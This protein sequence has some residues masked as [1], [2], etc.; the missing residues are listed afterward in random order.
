MPSPPSSKA[1]RS[2]FQAT[3]SH[4]AAPIVVLVAAMFTS[5][6]LDTWILWSA[7]GAVAGYSLSGST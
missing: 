2:G 5:V 4:P 3:I 1:T 7:A 6:W